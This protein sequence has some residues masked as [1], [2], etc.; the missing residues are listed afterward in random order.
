MVTY[1]RP[2]ARGRAVWGELVPYGKLW[3]TGAD[4]AT[5]ISFT[6]DVKLGDTPVKAGSY[7]LFTIPE[8]DKWTI[9]LNS[10]AEQWGSYDHDASKDVA[11]A[12]V[13]P[14]KAEMA[15]AFT[16][17]ADGGTL[18]LHWA[19]LRAPVPLSAE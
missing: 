7:A 5:V 12:E 18:Y 13:T 8:Q 19:E 2:E 15:E 3:R 14:E 1:G 17:E 10:V 9:V 6:G 11:R 4:E 16:V